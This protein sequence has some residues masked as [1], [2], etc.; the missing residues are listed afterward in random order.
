MALHGIALYRLV[1]LS[2]RKSVHSANEM[3]KSS[4]TIHVVKLV[5]YL[6]FDFN[7]STLTNNTNYIVRKAVDASMH[8]GDGQTGV[9]EVV[10]GFYQ[11]V[12]EE[13]NVAHSMRLKDYIE[14]EA[15]V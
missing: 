6:A 7:H 5:E 11:L 14:K 8:G 3:N 9:G 15:G 13:E 12:V 1:L 4:R 10:T 2:G